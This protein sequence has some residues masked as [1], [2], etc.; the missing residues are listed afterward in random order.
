MPTNRRQSSLSAIDD[1][2]AAVQSILEQHPAPTPVA[3]GPMASI[4]DSHPHATLMNGPVSSQ[5]P[6]KQFIIGKESGGR[7][8]AK[9]P[10][11]S[12]FGVGQLLIGNRQKFAKQLG[13]KD[14]NTTDP[15]E[16][17]M[18]MDQYV[19]ERYGDYKK[20]ASFWKTHG[21]Y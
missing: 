21:W 7:T 8:N 13:I 11:S 9:N 20:A 3:V 4:P 10:K 12:A 2:L 6:D 17:E 19:K 16:Q 5:D 15:H 14:P 1:A 18:M